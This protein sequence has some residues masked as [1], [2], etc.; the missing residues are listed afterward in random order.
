M[1]LFASPVSLAAR[2]AARE[3]PS[4]ASTYPRALI[5]ASSRLAG[6]TSVPPPTP[7]PPPPPGAVRELQR[8]TPGC[9]RRKRARGARAGA[10]GLVEGGAGVAGGGG[11]S[12]C[13][14]R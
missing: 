10:R 1:S 7:P 6:A 11:G 2:A 8:P 5:T 9:R 3:G 13:G 14:E 12:G 4:P